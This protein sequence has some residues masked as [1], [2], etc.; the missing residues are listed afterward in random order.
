METY[1]L[2]LQWVNFDTKSGNV[3]L[4]EFTSKMTLN[5]GSLH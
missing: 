3:F 1:G 2:E 5:E 4:L